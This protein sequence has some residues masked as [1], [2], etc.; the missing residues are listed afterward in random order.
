MV[1]ESGPGLN[2]TAKFEA[3]FAIWTNRERSFRN[4]LKDAQNRQKEDF[5][6]TG[7]ECYCNSVPVSCNVAAGA[8]F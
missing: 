3:C 2:E 5:I 8:Y 1:W 7:T 4:G 6:D